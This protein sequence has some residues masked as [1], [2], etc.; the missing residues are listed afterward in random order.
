M[1]KVFESLKTFTAILKPVITM[2]HIIDR[3][4]ASW[5]VR[6]VK[7]FKLVCASAQTDQRLSIIS[8][9]TLDHWLSIE[10]HRRL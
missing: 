5:H 1:R 7:R 10:R 6:T 4:P 3:Y 2:H 8:Q 9:E